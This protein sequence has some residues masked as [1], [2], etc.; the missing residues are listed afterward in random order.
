MSKLPKRIQ[1][2]KDNQGKRAEKVKKE[3]DIFIEEMKEEDRKTTKLMR[4]L[5]Y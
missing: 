1:E 2:I 3:M 5:L 4:K